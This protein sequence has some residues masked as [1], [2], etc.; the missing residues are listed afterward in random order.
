MYNAR[1]EENRV[2]TISLYGNGYRDFRDCRLGRARTD[3]EKQRAYT[4][5]GPN[6]GLYVLHELHLG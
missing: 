6:T 5:S 3:H 4:C 2:A 1:G